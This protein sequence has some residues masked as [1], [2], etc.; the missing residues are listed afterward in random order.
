MNLNHIFKNLYTHKGIYIPNGN[1]NPNLIVKTK[2]FWLFAYVYSQASLWIH[3]KI[4]MHNGNQNPNLLIKNK[5][6]SLFAYA[7]SQASLWILTKIHK[8]ANFVKY[9]ASLHK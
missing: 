5:S 9:I 2:S 6:I 1:Q 8:Y 4:H 7:Y 3:T